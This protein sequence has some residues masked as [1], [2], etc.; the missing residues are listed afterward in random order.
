MKQVLSQRQK[1][2]KLFQF[3][4]SYIMYKV[5]HQRALDRAVEMF[6]EGL[7]WLPAAEYYLENQKTLVT[8]IQPYLKDGWIWERLPY[9][10][11]AL[12]LAILSESKTLK[13][14]K[15]IIINEAVEIIKDFCD[16]K[17]YKYIN[18]VLDAILK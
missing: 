9:A 14:P 5:D 11:Q 6:S 4:Y 2:I 13:T 16:L 7:D 8:E 18:S 3:I 1:R 12:M 17:S 10:E 15:S